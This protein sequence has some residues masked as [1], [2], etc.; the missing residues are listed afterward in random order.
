MAVRF[1]RETR[2][3][4]RPHN[5]KP[6]RSPRKRRELLPRVKLRELGE[7][8]TRER[9]PEMR[10][11]NLRRHRR[12]VDIV[13]SWAKQLRRV[14]ARPMRRPHRQDKLPV[15]VD[16][17]APTELSIFKLFPHQ[18]E[19]PRLAN[20][21]RVNE[22]VQ[23]ARLRDKLDYPLFTEHAPRARVLV[24]NVVLKTVVFETVDRP[25]SIDGKV[26]IWLRG[27]TKLLDQG[28]DSL[29]TL[30]RA[31]ENCH[32]ANLDLADPRLRHPKLCVVKRVLC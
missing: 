7:K 3:Q 28:F 11:V 29:R 13:A 24:A 21:P 27:I 10:S 15:A 5:L 9:R 12:H 6:K 32:P 25:I 18:G 20:P 31:G 17:R 26:P 30:S 8:H 22:P 4:L 16:A 19:P 14:S 23:V 2:I 1:V